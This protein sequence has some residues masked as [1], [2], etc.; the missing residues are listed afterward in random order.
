[1]EFKGITLPLGR[2]L[3]HWQ[4]SQVFTQACTSLKNKNHITKL[5]RLSSTLLHVHHKVDHDNVILKVIPI[6]IPDVVEELLTIIGIKNCGLYST[7]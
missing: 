7:S 2:L 4:R 1:M 3:T 5:K 6:R